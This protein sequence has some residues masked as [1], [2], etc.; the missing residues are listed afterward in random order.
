MI[1][2]ITMVALMYIFTLYFIVV[3]N[4]IYMMPW[5]FLSNATEPVFI[6]AIYWIWIL[7]IYLLYV[8]FYWVHKKRIN[9]NYM[10]S[11][12]AFFPIFIVF[13]FGYY[14]QYDKWEFIPES[15]FETRLQ[16][17]EVSD[18]EN[19]LI[20]LWRIFE[21]N[22]IEKSTLNDFD[23]I[24]GSNYR[25]LTW[26]WVKKCEEDNLKN[27]I[28]LYKKNYNDIELLN[29]EILKVVNYKYFK[30][31]STADR[32]TVLNW[33]TSLSRAS[34]YGAI[35]YLQEWTT[36]K[37]L[38]L[39]LIYKKLWDKLLEWDTTVV[40]MIVWISIWRVALDNISYILDNYELD[41]KNLNIL[42][43]ELSSVYN[44]EVIFSNTI[45]FEYWT[46]K[47]WFEKWF[48][49]WWVRSSM[50]LDKEE[51]YNHSRK[52]WLSAIKWEWYYYENKPKNY[53]KREF[54]YRIFGSISY[55]STQWYKEDIENV[56][57]KSKELLE[58]IELKLGE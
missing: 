51:L 40:W 32:Y 7:F 9:K 29:D 37:A 30:E 20:H 48:N 43:E 1:L 46:H 28:N 33:L 17:I 6:V 57:I 11:Y 54:I 25:C 53:F 4:F 24:V 50:L 38:E 21:N 35:Y 36:E 55:F 26:N 5:E 16:N 56:N 8:L 49:N 42:K 12:L 47:Y 10:Y 18:K 15:T 27:A 52:L 22:K 58:K 14:I 39:L 34:L 19:G 44:A 3:A 41:D 13:Y 23:K 2:N 31:D 45:K